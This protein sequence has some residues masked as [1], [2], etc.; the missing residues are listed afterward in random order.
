MEQEVPARLH[1]SLGRQM[2]PSAEPSQ[3]VPAR[4]RPGLPRETSDS[5]G[6]QKRPRFFQ[7]ALPKLGGRG[8]APAP[9]LQWQWLHPPPSLSSSARHPREMAAGGAREGRTAAHGPYLWTVGLMAARLPRVAGVAGAAGA[10]AAVASFHVPS[11]NV[12]L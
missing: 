9:R 12:I 1:T 4:E 11:S 8:A 3:N 6:L 10:A 2:W 7:E 5:L